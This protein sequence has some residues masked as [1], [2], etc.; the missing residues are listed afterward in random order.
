M[1]NGVP[2]VV[3]IDSFK[4]LTP[5]ATDA[6]EYRTFLHQLAGAVSAVTGSSF[7]LGEYSQDEIATAPE[8]AV[9]DGVIVA[10]HA[11]RR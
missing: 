5:Y 11:H 6:R 1:R 7:W 9:A 4:A 10:R 2:G 8:F 3:V